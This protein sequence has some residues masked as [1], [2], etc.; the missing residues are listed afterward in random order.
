MNEETNALEFRDT[1]DFYN[2]HFIR[3]DGRNR[4]LDGFSDVSEFYHPPPGDGE[5]DIPINERGGR[6]FRLILDGKPS[7]ENPWE[8]MRDENGVPLLRWDPKAKKI[9]PRTERDILADTEAMKP[10]L[11][12]HVKDGIMQTHKI[13][14]EALQV[15]I[16]HRDRKYSV[17]ME[18]Q[19][20]LSAQLGLYGLNTQAGIPTELSWN[21]TGEVCEPWEFPALLELA[22]AMKSYVAPL[23]QMQREAEVDIRNAKGGKEVLARVDRFG[24]DIRAAVGK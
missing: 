13:L 1:E 9:L 6:H 24:Y 18:K 23:A 4:V 17:T 15:P 20:L 12:A 21:A 8:L 2:T 11:E 3:V 14:A 7:H 5:T 22:N 10:P 16:E 19:N